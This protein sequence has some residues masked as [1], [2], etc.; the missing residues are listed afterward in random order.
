MA[1]ENEIDIP[2]ADAEI[3]QC[4]TIN[5]PAKKLFKVLGELKMIS[6]EAKCYYE[7]EYNTFI[8]DAEDITDLYNQLGK[9]ISH[10]MVILG[11]HPDKGVL[12]RSKEQYDKGSPTV[13]LAGALKEKDKE[14]YAVPDNAVLR[15]YPTQK[16]KS[17]VAN[18]AAGDA[19]LLTKE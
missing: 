10:V 2:T 16:F 12:S 5:E 19:L 9:T 13:I 6:P 14:I 17:S 11:A 4:I 18:N 3:K 15:E 1:K 8:F 7:Y